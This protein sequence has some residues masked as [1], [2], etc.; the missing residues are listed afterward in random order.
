MRDPHHRVPA[1]GHGLLVKPAGIQGA[2]DH[3]DH[4]PAGRDQTGEDPEQG[5]PL[6]LPGVRHIGVQDLPGHGDGL[7]AVDD[8]DRQDREA[9]AQAGRIQGQVGGLPARED[10]GQQGAKQVVTSSWLRRW[11]DLAAA[12]W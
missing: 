12:G 10:P 1:Q 11:P 6:R 7:A 8:A 9:V 3:H 2:V 5:D 4:R